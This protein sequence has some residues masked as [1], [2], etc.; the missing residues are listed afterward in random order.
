MLR[1]EDLAPF[2]KGR[3]VSEIEDIWQ[4]S[5][6]SS[7]WRSGPVLNNALSGVDQGNCVQVGL[8][9]VNGCA[10]SLA[11]VAGCMI[12]PFSRRSHVCV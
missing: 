3:R 11:A 6:L 5:Y 7:Y 10:G 12:P 8:P 9:S 2:L 4:S 1:P